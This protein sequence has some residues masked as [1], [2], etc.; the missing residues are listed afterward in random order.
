M[1]LECN[2]YLCEKLDEMNLEIKNI[3]N[4]LNKAYLA[5][6]PFI[7]DITLFKENYTT[8]LKAIQPNDNEETLKDYI[9][10]FLKNT[11]YKGRFA[12]K[13]NVKNIDLVI[14]NGKEIDS[15][16][17]VIVETKAI[18]SSEM[19][20]ENELN[21]KAFQELIQYYLEE[22]VV[23][24]N[25]EIKHLI[26]TNSIDWFIFNASEF[27][28]LFYQN[29]SF[30][31]QYNDWHSE[32]LVSKNKD[33]FYSE[34]AK[35]FV[36]NSEENIVCTYVNLQ[37]FENFE[38]LD[39][40][41]IIELYKIFSPEHLLKLPFQND[42][43]TLNRE[44]YNELLH[45][46]GL[47]ETKVNNVRRIERL[48]ETERN[49]GSFIENTI[50]ILL[51]DEIIH[52]LPEPERFGETEEEQLYSVGLELCITWLNRILFL[53]LLESQLVKYNKLSERSDFRFLNSA[54]IRDFEE[55]R[56][57][58]FEVLAVKTA[59]RKK[60]F[61]TKYEK[62]P[63]LNSSLFELTELEIETVKINQLKNH[64]ELPVFNATVLKDDSGKK[65]IGTKPILQYLFEFLDSYNFASDNK[66]EIQEKN[67]T[68]INSSV[69]GLIFEKI[70]GYKEGSYYTP[71]F[72]TMYMCRENI[73]KAVIE[74]FKP[75]LKLSVNLELS[76]SWTE[77]Y[78]EIDKIPI[79]Q[80]N[81]IFNSIKICDPAVGSGHFLVSALNELVAIKSDL[82]IL[83]DKEG[84]RLRN[85]KIEVI[86]DELY[87]SDEG[88]LFSYHYKNEDSQTIQETI[89]HEK[90]KLIENCLFGVDINP[91]SVNICRLR[92]W[93][94]LL[95]NAYYEVRTG[96]A[97]S[98]QTLPNIDI[99]IKCGNSL[100]SHFSLNGNGKNGSQ[101]L[102]RN[103]E[104]YKIQVNK[105]KN[106]T[107]RNAKREYEKQILSAKENFAQAVN[108]N[109][110]DLKNIRKL[111]SEQLEVPMFFSKEEHEQYKLKHKQLETELQDLK[112]KYEE[113]KKTI[114]QNAFEWRFEF[115]EVLDDNG[116]F[117][118]FDL[119]IGNPPYFSVSRFPKQYHTY[120]N[121]IGYKTYTKSTDIYCLF[122]ELSHRILAKNGHCSFITSSQWLQTEYGNKLKDFFIN[123]TNPELL[124][125]MGSFKVFENATVDTTIF[126]YGKRELKN[127]L[128]LCM[129]QANENEK[130]DL[131]KY[132]KA[133]SFVL[134]DLKTTKWSFENENEKLLREKIRNTGRK[135]C[136][137]NVEINRGIVTGFNEA[138]FIDEKTKNELIKKDSK[139]KQIIKKVL[140]GR[141]LDKFKFNYNN[142]YLIFTR[143]GIN[144]EKFPAIKEY[145][146]K[147]KPDLKPK[148]KNTDQAGRKP[149]VY[150]WFEIQDVT[151]YYEKF[152]EP[153]LIYPETT[154][155]RG[156]FF[157]D[158]SGMF[159]D[160]TCFMITGE[161][162]YYF[163][164]IL[165]SILMEWYLEG[166]ARL[167]GKQGIQYSKRFMELIPIPEINEKQELQIT[168]IVKEIYQAV[169]NQKS[170][171][172]LETKLNSIV[173]KLYNLSEDEIA[174]I[175]R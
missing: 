157:V 79:K 32:K 160:K 51:S 35:P 150:K 171:E 78:N 146:E 123:F 29:K 172:K 48:N 40:Q 89:F 88:Q 154:G 44:F 121:E 93:I 166:E 36:E 60:V 47:Q 75:I 102:K 140:R 90:Q 156:E 113:K 98:L 28:R 82:K 55:L 58:F 52:H 128:S 76:E 30:L 115:P 105:Y 125:S 2:L 14:L 18:K 120:F 132:Y 27:E 71:G 148:N 165:S 50:H 119:I 12:T 1:L 24:E 34:I 141:N 103:T 86:N 118:G 69:L 61:Q 129:F 85:V 77:L 6:S 159:L 101:S 57:L 95:K 39:D 26:I 130:I 106:T 37:G 122:F 66:A 49:D 138:F 174:I 144:I 139:S 126:T 38:G 152:K 94:E 67:K 7:D 135:L 80:A 65:T 83:I 164:A 127:E 163:N 117:V 84:R 42:S 147:F 33:W 99:N 124:Y 13:E 45:I 91:K 3:C 70:N 131:I 161:H 137:W 74:K 15:S 175:E 43:N 23:N 62:I 25:I 110:E 134:K 59:D 17:G 155:G 72:V 41:Q 168:T 162:L 56:E 22:R 96:H 73:R 54:K 68:I 136:D 149:G 167:L 46:L 158:E 92:L 169:S 5:Q 170:I 20:T 114:Y 64:Y 107:D 145:L 31:K 8:L 21:K 143:R 116:Y 104:E 108:P 100:I 153:K 63:Y 16:I 173:Y 87:I 133:N 142:L 151:A 10:D 9:N 4:S 81:E 11:Y 53:K 97:P 109:D 112:K 111:E 19:I